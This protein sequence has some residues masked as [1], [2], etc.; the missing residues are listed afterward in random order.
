MKIRNILA[1]SMAA[2]CLSASAAEWKVSANQ[3]SGKKPTSIKVTKEKPVL[4]FESSVKGD[5]LVIGLSDGKQKFGSPEI[6][7]KNRENTY[8][9]ARLKLSVPL[10]DAKAATAD[11][12]HL[13]TKFTH[14]GV[15]YE[16]NAVFN[17]NSDL[18]DLVLSSK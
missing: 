9:R 8:V 18:P 12:P 11:K 14:G 5:A 16:L 1:V 2:T 4:L 13:V 3:L 15:D 10:A 17:A 7:I 6:I